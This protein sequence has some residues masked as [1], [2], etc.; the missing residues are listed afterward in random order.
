[1]MYEMMYEVVG[2][3]LKQHIW[4]LNVGSSRFVKISIFKN[5]WLLEI[6]IA[7]VKQ[8]VS[9]YLNLLRTLLL[10]VRF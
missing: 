3:I 7:A 1:M 6:K 2:Y 5:F 8:N 4:K 10:S 9:V